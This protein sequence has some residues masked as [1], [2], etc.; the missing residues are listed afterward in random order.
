MLC[1]KNIILLGLIAGAY[2]LA[3]ALANR[4][5]K[6]AKEKLAEA[7]LEQKELSEV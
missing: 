7:R 3:Q 4:P 6:S 1:H 2:N 5:S